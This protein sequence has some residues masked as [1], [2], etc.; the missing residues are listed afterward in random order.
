MI[1]KGLRA[2]WYIRADLPILA[3]KQIGHEKWTVPR[4]HEYFRNVFASK[5]RCLNTP[6]I[7]KTA[8]VQPSSPRPPSK[9]FYFKDT[10]TKVIQQGLQ[11]SNELL[12]I[13]FLPKTDSH[14]L[15]KQGF[16]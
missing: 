12:T 6:V 11:P 9:Q 13:K 1:E 5:H 15:H 3:L 2:S 10:E 4:L 14:N 16:S 8:G 7:I